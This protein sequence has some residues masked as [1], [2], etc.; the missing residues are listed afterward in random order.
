MSQPRKRFYKE[1]AFAAVKGGFAVLL[2]G[3]ATR[4]PGAKPFLLPTEALAEAIAAEWRAQGELIHPFS[5]PLTQLSATA[6]DRV[7]EKGAGERAAMEEAILKYAATDL[8][9]YRA[10]TPVELAEKQAA[11]WQPLLDWA[12]LAL[13]APLRATNGILP[14]DQPVPALLSL[15]R[16]MKGL[17]LW[18]FAAFQCAASAAGSFILGAALI[19]AR[20]DAEGAIQAAQLDE[21]YQRA[22]WGEDYEATLRL[23]QQASDIRAAER[24]LGLLQGKAD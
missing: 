17:D 4:T 1:A 16:W 8:L 5:M 14:V 20:L 15:E 6:L 12:A 2:D 3:R 21:T 23:E 7:G 13:D 11:S 9:C 19:E 24:L 18:R 10:S 22:L